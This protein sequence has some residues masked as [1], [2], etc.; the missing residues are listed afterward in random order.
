M[1]RLHRFETE[2]IISEEL[3]AKV[4]EAL[5]IPVEDLERSK[6]LDKMDLERRFEEWC[7]KSEPPHL[8]IR[9]IPGVYQR[10]WVP[11]SL[12]ADQLEQYAAG[13]AAARKR[14]TCLV[15]NREESVWF[16]EEGN[17]RFRQK[18]TAA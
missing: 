15:L 16:D 9:L 3:L 2:G 17:L 12:H 14:P 10:Q 4:A 5:A 13:T 11:D 7:G 1:Q 6:E 8:I 18:A